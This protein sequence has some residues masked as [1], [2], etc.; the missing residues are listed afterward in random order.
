MFINYKFKNNMPEGYI[1]K[2]AFVNFRD[3][4]SMYADVNLYGRRIIEVESDYGSGL[5]HGST[6]DIKDVQ[7]V[8][9]K[10]RRLFKI[11]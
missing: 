3:G 6:K 8:L 10:F 1:R 7:Y 5:L 2:F 9:P 4:R 11:T